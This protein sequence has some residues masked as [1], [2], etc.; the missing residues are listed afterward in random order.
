MC[1]LARAKNWR[2]VWG[3]IVLKAV[4]KNPADRYA[5]A[6][7]LAEDVLRVQADEPISAYREPVSVRAWR[8]A[9]KHRVLVTSLVAALVVAVPILVVGIVL[10]NQS[11]H[12][13]R[14]ARE[15]EEQA[16]KDEEKARERAQANY[17]R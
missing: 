12:R 11:E 5:G 8:W 6:K 15:Q 16:R 17:Q 1:W 2:T 13:E 10:L 14:T 9:R 7:A 3:R 4:S